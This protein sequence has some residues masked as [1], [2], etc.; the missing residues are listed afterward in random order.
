MQILK[1]VWHVTRGSGQC[2]L[3][4]S[5][6][7][8][9]RTGVHRAAGRAYIVHRRDVR[10]FYNRSIFHVPQTHDG[11]AELPFSGLNMVFGKGK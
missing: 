11:A 5:L 3:T 6:A 9:P 1:Y 10:L 2:G 7:Y 4:S 8:L